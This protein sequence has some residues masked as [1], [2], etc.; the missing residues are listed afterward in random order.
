MDDLMRSQ[1]IKNILEVA[2]DLFFE[3]G[4]VNTKVSDIAA[5]SEISTASI[6]KAFRS[7]DTLYR[8][9]LE[10][11]IE[12]LK[13]LARPLSGEDDPISQLLKASDHYQKLCT[14]ALFQDLI[15]APVEHN[16]IPM[17]FRRTMCRQLR[18]ALEQM[19]MPALKACAAGGFLDPQQIKEA[20]RL[21]SAYIEHQ[22]IWYGLFVGATVGKPGE[23]VPIADE[24][25]RI[26]LAAYPLKTGGVPVPSD[27]A[28]QS[29]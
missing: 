8:A 14:S 15:R 22:T 27:A 18:S 3:F 10:D 28:V 4:F 6:Y 12:R 11:G 7:K 21:L 1:Q 13:L 26:V 20:F 9:V 23:K 5:R 17:P 24:A 29:A 19:C 2:G 16:S 25:V